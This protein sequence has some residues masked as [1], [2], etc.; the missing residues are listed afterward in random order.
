MLDGTLRIHVDGAEHRGE[1][2]TTVF[3]PRD[4]PH[5]YV[6]ESE[7]ARFLS[8]LTPGSAEA[9][10][11]DGGEPAPDHAAPPPGSMPIERIRA[12]AERT[13]HQILGPPPF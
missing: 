1:A 4:M 10:Y 3:V 5:A 7:T 11:R 13:G 9:F 8:I 2:G 12:A 6:V